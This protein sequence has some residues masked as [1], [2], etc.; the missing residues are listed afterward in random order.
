MARKRQQSTQQSFPI[1]GI[2][3]SAG[4]FEAF[5]Q[6]LET[7]PA[8]T[9]MAFVLVQHLDPT[10]ESKLTELLSRATRLPVVE[11]RNRM[12][13]KPDHV[14]VIPPNTSMV[15]ADG[16]LK[17]S[18]RAAGG[19]HI[20]PVDTFFRSLAEERGHKAVGVI[21]SGTA[22]DGAEGIRAIKLQGGIT[23]AQDEKSAKYVGMPHAAMATGCVD[24]VLPPEAITEEL[25]QISRHPYVNHSH[26]GATE[27]LA[28]DQVDAFHKILRLLR[29]TSGVDFTHYKPNTLQRR[30]RRRMVVHK[31]DTLERYARFL[32]SNPTEAQTLFED[33][34]I[35]VTGFFRDADVFQALK[36]KVLPRIVRNRRASEAIRVWVPGCSTGEEVYS[37][38][39]CLL[40]YLEAKGVNFPVQLFGTDISDQ[41]LD[42]ARN[43]LYP[44]S[45]EADVSHQRRRRYF[46]RAQNGYQISKSIRELCIF[47]KQN[48]A[49]DPPFSGLD[50]ISCR[51]LLIYLGPTLQK[52]VMPVFHYAPKPKGFLVLGGSESITGFEN[53]FAAV[54]EK[55]RIFSKKATATRAKLDFSYSDYPEE[56]ATVA[57]TMDKR[58]WGELDVQREAD[59]V[60]LGRYA[61]ASVL[62]ND[63][64]EI[65]Q[66]RGHT[67]QYIEPSPG[68]ASLNLL[69][70]VRE[71]L[72]VEL[73]AALTKAGK[74]DVTVRKEGLR[75]KTNGAFKTTNVEVVPLKIPGTRE[76]YF[77]I[78][79][80]EARPAAAR[81]AEP[82]PA[83]PVR[84]EKTAAERRIVRLEQELAGTK[85]YMQSVVEELEGANEELKAANEE[86]Q[87]SNEELQSTNEELETAKE[88]LQST[89]EELTTVNEE[90]QTRNQELGQLNNDLNNLLVSVTIPILM[91]S[92]DLRIRR[93]T[94][95]A[96]KVLHLTPSDLG[97]S[98]GSLR[99]PI[100]ASVLERLITDAIDN[101]TVKQREVQ[102][103]DGHWYSLQVRPYRTTDNRIDGAVIALL[104]VDALKHSLEEADHA[105]QYAEAI[106][107]TVRK[108]LLVLEFDL[109]VRSANSAFYRTFGET[110]ATTEGRFIYDLGNGQW[111]IP[112]LRLLLE[113]ILP[114]HSIFE[115]FE[116]TQEFPKIG[117]RTVLLNA[118]QLRRDGTSGEMILLA[119]EDITERQ[120]LQK[121]ILDI[122]EQER[123]RMGRDVHD[124]LGQ[125]LTGI[126]FMTEALCDKLKARSPSDAADATK[127]V[128]RVKQAVDL[129]HDLARGLYP[130]QLATEGIGPALRTL[131]ADA[132]EMFD[133]SC[134]FVGDEPMQIRDETVARHLYRIAQEAVFNA[135]KHSKGKRVRVELVQTNG[136]LTLTI[137]DDGKGFSKSAVKST[138]MGLHIMDYRA[139]IIGAAL[140]IRSAL[141][142]GT[143]V[144]CSLE[145]PR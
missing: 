118:R 26:A 128:K 2:G 121:A 62:V 40:E 90:L 1:V 114:K 122:G 96:E 7:L 3:A 42:R 85:D 135:A 47:A 10:H 28:T 58:A 132:E 16:H 100:D 17:L 144:V 35:N 70:M 61:P 14:Y 127:I 141:R 71:G 134:E 48:I 115:D 138:A 125:Q 73:R 33:L 86:I 124:G 112:A 101:L 66:F 22:S 54:D 88:E 23:F 31:L 21:L 13:V 32:K 109:R 78:L 64:L 19:G 77:L 43:G 99:L 106:V 44:D 123:E 45:I 126:A 50:L 98:I 57:P 72:H 49:K 29:A 105:K 8:D 89:N 102:D 60:L 59:R 80:E 97:R 20:L 18:P 53:L 68:A 111:N 41:A 37:L 76:R 39:I 34:L 79:F 137:N 119:I 30:I 107:E 140:E 145:P 84:L 67:G 36:K 93:I 131:A 65:L 92:A 27:E 69:K 55:R 38:A 104:D 117:R 133:V 83:K 9:G 129:A 116:M 120:H 130:V 81:A 95:M 110:K 11:V 74:Q 4:G 87:S 15:I 25:A 12:P 113:D 139:R 75:V 6:L 94:P 142:K 24:F 82:R 51:N 136:R 52:R 56:P 143:T 63:D 103:R 91:L 46:V 108:P 5:K